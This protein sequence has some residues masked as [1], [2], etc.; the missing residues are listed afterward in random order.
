MQINGGEILKKR[1]W[2]S[3]TTTVAIG[4]GF[5]HR[6]GWG[7]LLI[8]HP[9]LVNWLLRLKLTDSNRKALS[10][11]HEFQHLQS[12]PIYLI[13][14]L[15]MLANVFLK[16]P[17]NYSDI[18]I[19]FVSSHAAWE[20]LSES[21]TFFSNIPLYSESYSNISVF[22]RLIFWISCSIVAAIGWLFII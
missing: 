8:P 22:P 19:V 1:T 13:Y 16:R 20:L 14:T 10:I 17:V 5:I 9:P 2:Y 21:L 11:N 18:F 15:V 7:K 4:P 6:A 3:V 12:A